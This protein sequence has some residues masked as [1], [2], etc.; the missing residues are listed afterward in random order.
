M[1]KTLVFTIIFILIFSIFYCGKEKEVRYGKAFPKSVPQ[2][3]NYENITVLLTDMKLYADAVK[4]LDKEV[5]QKVDDRYHDV[6]FRLER[7]PMVLSAAPDPAA[8]RVTLLILPKEAQS[9]SNILLE[10]DRKLPA[11]D[12]ET[13]ELQI[14]SRDENAMV[15]CSF[16][17]PDPAAYINEFRDHDLSATFTLYKKFSQSGTFDFDALSYPAY[18]THGYPFIVFDLVKA[19]FTDKTANITC[20]CRL[21]G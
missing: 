2:D 15:H 20:Q 13:V 16:S 17:V 3:L 9:G 10:F 1:R 19:E 4:S 6:Y 21:Q 8:G 12:T 11:V 5:V 14:R 7:K 18:R